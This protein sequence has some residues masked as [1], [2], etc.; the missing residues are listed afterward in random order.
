MIKTWYTYF[1]RCND[2][3]VYAGI[4]TELARRVDEHNSSVLG[5]KYTRNKRPV[6]LVY[7]ETSESRSQASKKE[8]ALKRLTKKQKEH[9][10]KTF[11]AERITQTLTQTIINQ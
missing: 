2:N 4:T 3:S 1:V 10:I 5:A 6:S 7:F 11:P 8:Y 9:L